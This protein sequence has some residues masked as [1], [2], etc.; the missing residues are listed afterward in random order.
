[1]WAAMLGMLDGIRARRS[2]KAMLEDFGN[3]KGAGALAVG[4]E[5]TGGDYGR[6][7]QK[8]FSNVYG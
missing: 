1:M 2:G 3:E 8:G 7:W 5:R 4:L 6:A